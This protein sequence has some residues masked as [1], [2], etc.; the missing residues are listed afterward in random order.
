MHFC[1]SMLEQ[2]VSH[3]QAREALRAHFVVGNCKPNGSTAHESR[4]SQDCKLKREL[5]SCHKE[6]DELRHQVRH[7]RDEVDEMR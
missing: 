4:W 6:N 2:D 7:Y 5:D 1:N 3:W